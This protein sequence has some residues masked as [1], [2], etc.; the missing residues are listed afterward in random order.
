MR[1]TY[2]GLFVAF[3]L[4]G[5]GS[6]APFGA[7][8]TKDVTFAETS[9]LALLQE[10]SLIHAGDEFTLAG[11]DKGMVRWG[12][13]ALDGTLTQE[14]SFAMT[15]PVAG[16]VFAATMKTSPGDQLIAIALVTATP[17]STGYALTAT[18]HTVGAA[19][20]AAPIVLGTQ[21]TITPDTDP[22]TFQ[23]AAGAAASGKTGYV[24]WGTRVKGKPIH[25]LLLPADAVTTAAPSTF[26]G[27]SLPQDVPEWDCLASQDRPA[28]FSF[29]AVTPVVPGEASDFQTTDIDEEG[30]T[31]YMTYPLDA[32][33]TGCLIKGS[34]V[35][36]TTYFI[37]FQGLKQGSTA[38]DFATYYQPDPKANGTV[39]TYHPVLPAA[40]FGGPL[41]MPRPAWVSSA[42]GDVVI[43]LS[44]KAG[45]EVVRYTYNAIPHGSKLSLRSAN[46]QA[47]P[48]AAWVGSDAVYA[49]Y[50]DQVKSGNAT[51]TKRYFMRIEVPASLP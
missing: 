10:V 16:P 34:P 38:I 37:A 22:S 6:D 25:Y 45:P 44:R 33:V 42:G 31:T 26:L 28:G 49:T 3:V 1:H 43:G 19:D 11:Y 7:A 36:P 30:G 35:D 23:L 40:L 41:G 5:C 32:E 14:T 50:T 24:A 8:V 12:R 39:T 27:A 51:V 9:Q 29:S 4:V 21:D 15:Q 47:G 18:V 13:V 2:R 46:G 48:V 17:P 20:P